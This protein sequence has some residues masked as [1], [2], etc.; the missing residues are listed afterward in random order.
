MTLFSS[1]LSLINLGRL[2]R[3]HFCL[4]LKSRQLSLEARGTS[5]TSTFLPVLLEP[6]FIHGSSRTTF[7]QSLFSSSAIDFADVPH[8]PHVSCLSLNDL[9]G[10][11]CLKMT[12]Q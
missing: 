8:V 3:P 12:S 5:G 2:G 10:T 1:R 4:L 9:S 7:T 11:S 6:I